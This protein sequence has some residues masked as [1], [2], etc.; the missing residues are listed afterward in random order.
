MHVAF[1]YCNRLVHNVFILYIWNLKIY[2]KRESN[3]ITIFE[4]DF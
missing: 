1:F 4:Y 3:K 2:F